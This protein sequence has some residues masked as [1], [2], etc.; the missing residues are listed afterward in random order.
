[1]QRTELSMT[2]AAPAPMRAGAM[3][4]ARD[5]AGLFVHEWGDGH[6]VVFVHAWAVSSAMWAYQTACLGDRGA[7]CILYD[8]RGHGRSD[9]AA[10]GFDL[11]TLAD[12]LA[13]VVEG[14]DL[15]DVVL[16]GH[17]MGGAEII[18][19]L[20]RH[21]TGRIAKVALLAPATPCLLESADNPRGAP[22]A[23]FES[24]RAE[25]L[26]DFPKWIADNK[27]PFFTP[28]TSPAMIDWL[29]SD[30]LRTP[31]GVAV[32]CNRALAERDLRPD[33]ARIDRPVLIL[34]GDNDASAPLEIT[35]RPTAAGIAGA[36]LKIYP[37]APHGL[38]VTHM[39]RVNADLHAF[40]DA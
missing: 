37:G 2:M 11:D 4:R 6:P 13:A 24:L 31:V 21:G 19:Y 16:V 10:D 29:V 22:A 28:D 15:H 40:I 38:F 12:D 35:G 36:R 33:L 25:W 27:Q 9:P 5:G 39:A 8:R 17:S 7:R 14:L 18:R 3:I 34:H 32:A 23:Y 20:G 1:M 26:A 30:M